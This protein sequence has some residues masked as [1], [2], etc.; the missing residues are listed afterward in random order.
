MPPL[1]SS[2]VSKLAISL[3][4]WWR[5]CSKPLSFPTTISISPSLSI[6]IKVGGELKR[7]VDK[8]GKPDFILP[9]RSNA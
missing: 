2:P 5:I 9:F 1:I 6:S 7:F 3:P 4:S 8:N